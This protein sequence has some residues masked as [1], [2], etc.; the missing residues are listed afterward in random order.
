MWNVSFV[1]DMTKIRRKWK[2]EQWVYSR[3]PSMYYVCI[4]LGFFWPT[5]PLLSLSTAIPYRVSTGPE[6]RFPCVLFSN[7]EKPVFITGIPANG[8][9]VFPVRK[10]TQG[11]PCFH[12][13]DE[14][15]VLLSQ[16]APEKFFQLLWENWLSINNKNHEILG[17]GKMKKCFFRF[18]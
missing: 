18:F 5:H 6:Q 1:N 10:S 2:I 16:L 11:K 13:R 14:F 3:G 8:N 7:R 17:I 9:R 12:Y 4:I 15:A